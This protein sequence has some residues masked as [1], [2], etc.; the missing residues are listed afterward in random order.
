MKHSAPRTPGHSLGPLDAVVF[1]TDGVITRTASVHR[2]AWKRLFDEYLE[3]RG[4]G[5]RPFST[6]DYLAHVDGK[7]RYDGVEGFLTSRG[8]ALPHGDPTD[9]PEASTVCGLGNAKNRYFRNEIDEHG[10]ETYEGT[11]AFMADLRS[12]G[13]TLAAVSAS[14]NQRLVLE[15]AGLVEAF[16]ALV[17]GV[18][19]RDLGLAGKPDPALFLEAARRLGVTPDRAAVIED[20]RSGVAAG[21]AGGFVAVV[22]VDRS[23]APDQLRDA[24]ADLVVDDLAEMSLH[25][26][27]D[28][29]CSLRTGEAK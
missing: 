3:Q 17:D 8:I 26:D 15:A 25:R 19:S 18:M 14:E 6:E 22:G 7:P 29:Q 4:D 28:G 27:A 13:V 5:Q 10:V 16:D 9:S 11:V 23:S 20:A 12:C 1:D 21:R 2:A 24:G